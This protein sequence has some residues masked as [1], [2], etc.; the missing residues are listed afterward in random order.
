MA[1][2]LLFKC[3]GL[4]VGPQHSRK[5]WGRHHVFVTPALGIG[6][7]RDRWVLAAPYPVGADGLAGLMSSRFSERPSL[8]I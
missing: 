6:V 7:G 8:K 2:G 3:E 4:S 5:R 1:K